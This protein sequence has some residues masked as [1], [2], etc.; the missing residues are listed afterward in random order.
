[1][2]AFISKILSIAP[3]STVALTTAA[4]AV[5][6]A[7]SIPILVLRSRIR[8][9]KRLPP[10][11]KESD[12]VAAGVKFIRLEDGRLLEYHE[13]GCTDSADAETVLFFH[14]V[15]GTG[16]Y[17]RFQD[18]VFKQANVRIVAPTR[19]GYGFSDAV[20]DRSSILEWTRDVEQ[21]ADALKLNKF[22][23][24]G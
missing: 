7:I 20:Q 18:H 12:L 6:V 22:G 3:T 8:E 19:P 21:L 9:A 4:A 15:G 13:Y 16:E 2:V 11:C 23:I 5:T 1:M 10:P 14:G 24:I 17:L